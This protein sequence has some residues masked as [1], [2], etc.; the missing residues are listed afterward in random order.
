[1][2]AWA[3]RCM[4]DG[5]SDGR[6]Q[7]HVLTVAFRQGGETIHLPGRQHKQTLKKLFQE[8]DIPVWQRDRLPLLYIDGKLA[9]VSNH[10]IDR[11]FQAG[12]DEGGWKISFRTD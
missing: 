11:D 5:I 4:G 1:M 12:T 3:D 2:D 9:A 6:L 10:W 7:N 8:A